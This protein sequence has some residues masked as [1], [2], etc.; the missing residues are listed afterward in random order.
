MNAAIICVEQQEKYFDAC[1]EYLKRL[2]RY[3]SLS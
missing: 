2:T 1:N 3:S